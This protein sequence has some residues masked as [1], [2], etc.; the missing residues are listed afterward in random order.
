MGMTEC[1]LQGPGNF[2]I[3]IFLYDFPPPPPPA[4]LDGMVFQ[5]LL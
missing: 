5:D 4:P 2:K 1:I 3:M